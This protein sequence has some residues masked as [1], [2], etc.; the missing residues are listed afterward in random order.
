[1]R[2]RRIKRNET[3]RSRSAFACNAHIVYVFARRDHAF[4]SEAPTLSSRLIPSPKLLT[5]FPLLAIFPRCIPYIKDP[6]YSS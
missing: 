4:A 1:M 2:R 5:G 3:R 6:I